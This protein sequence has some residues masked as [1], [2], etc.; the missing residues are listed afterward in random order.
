VQTSIDG[1]L[2][3]NAEKSLTD[4]LAAKGDKAGVGQGALV[5]MTP[6]GAVRAMIGGRS[7]AD[8][9]FNRAVAAKRQPGSAFKAFVYLTALERGL[10]PDTVRE[11]RPIK[12]KDWQPE[13]YS[14]E[15]FGPVTLTKALAMSLNTVSVRLTLEMTPMAVIRTAHRLGIASKLEPNASIALGT[16]EVSMLELVGAYAAFAN[17]GY[18]VMPHVIERIT[19]SNGKVLY[20]RSGQQLGRIIEARYVAMMNAMMQETLTIGTAHKAALPGWPAAGKTGTS[21]D[22]RDAWFI[23]YTSKLVTGVWLGNDDGSPT[24][25]VTGGGMPVE[26]WSRFMRGAHQGVP[27][28]S[29]PGSGSAGGGLFSGLFGGG[30][31]AAP[32][33]QPAATVGQAPPVRDGAS[34]DGYLLN[35]LFGRR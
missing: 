30:N 28:A 14:R 21:Q 24:K 25:K 8:S 17:G 18:A 11:D 34:L 6:N 15:Y 19:A 12:V 20:T 5:A 26:I 32:A 1:A 35:N 4:E 22:F 33:P 23:G 7:Y 27:V 16:S 31:N 9:Q 29:L 10:T 3:A 13:N 2:Q